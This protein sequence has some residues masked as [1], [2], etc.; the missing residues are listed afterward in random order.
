MLRKSIFALS[1]L[2]SLPA[3]AFTFGPVEGRTMKMGTD[4]YMVVMRLNSPE[5]GYYR[6]AV[7]NKVAG[8]PQLVLAKIPA[9]F[10]ITIGGRNVI[11]HHIPICAQELN[12]MGNISREVCFRVRVP[13]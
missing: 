3:F 9:E 6:F 2:M 7:N 10:P 1:L 4:Q 5:G 11:D 8:D 12:P 13:E